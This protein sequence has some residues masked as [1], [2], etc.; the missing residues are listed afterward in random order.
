MAIFVKK[1]TFLAFFFV[2]KIN[3]FW[4]FFF[5]NFKFL[6]IF[7]HSNGNFLT[8][9]WQFFDIQMAIFQRVSLATKWPDIVLNGF[10]AHLIVLTMALNLT[11]LKLNLSMSNYLNFCIFKSYFVIIT[12]NFYHRPQVCKGFYL[13]SR[14]ESIWKLACE[15]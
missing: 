6:A 5:F 1:I 10:P 11:K 13:F 8:F 14:D 12:W 3:H 7:W 2:E 15:K 4:H 9:K